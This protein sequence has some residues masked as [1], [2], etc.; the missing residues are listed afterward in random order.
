LT[1]LI[2][3]TGFAAHS[4][5]WLHYRGPQL[6]GTS[7]EA[8]WQ[9]SWDGRAPI[10]WEKSLGIGA[11]SFTV[12]GNRVYTMGNRDNQDVVYCLDAKTGREIWSHSYPL[13]FD[14]RMFEGGT[15]AT[16]TIDGDRVYTLS[17]KGHLI[18]LN[19]LTGKVIWQKHLVNDFGG[20][21]SRWEY[22]GSPLVLDS[23]VIVDT[24][25]PTQST[26]AL[27]KLTGD[28]V[29][30]A[31]ADEAGYSSP[32]PFEAFGRRGVMV[33]KAKHLVAK[34]LASGAE[35]WRVPWETAYDVNASTPI[36]SGTR[37]FISTGYPKGRG[38]MF[39]L[40][41]TSPKKL[42]QND[43]I[44]TKMSSCAAWQ[45]YIYGVSERKEMIMCIDARDGKTVWE[46]RG[47]GQ[48]GNL[49]VAGGRLIILSDG[50]EL[51][52][53]PATPDGFK[54]VAR[55]KV[56]TDRCWV[57]PVLANGV[58]YCRNNKGTAVAVSVKP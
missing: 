46:S 24:G 44:K 38:A 41:P 52:I 15:A 2:A 31:G 57:Q 20:R 48:Y 7:L 33:F 18:C 27:N 25:S 37:L 54:P 3:L 51:I 56:L 36:T 30:G 23:M 45:G 49:I 39:E 16:P 6:N 11:S 42:W 19:N 58:I 4:A 32:L 14:A 21:L 17:H 26:I 1:W 43:D 35:M 9:A 55:A 10:L 22:A 5:D 12:Q 28:K 53:A 50:G 34:E 13:S 29:W 47:G 40:T 8:D